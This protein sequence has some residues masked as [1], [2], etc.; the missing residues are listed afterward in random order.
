MKRKTLEEKNP[1]TYVARLASTFFRVFRV[2][3]VF[4]GSYS[5]PYW[6]GGEASAGTSVAA[7]I[8]HLRIVLPFTDRESR[9]VPLR[10]TQTPRRKSFPGRARLDQLERSVL[11]PLLLPRFSFRSHPCLDICLFRFV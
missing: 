1:G 7:I 8:S 11:K 9:L 4:R 5:S 6:V 3:R 2:F 10:K